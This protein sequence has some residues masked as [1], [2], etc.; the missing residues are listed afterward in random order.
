MH[1]YNHQNGT[2]RPLFQIEEVNFEK[3]IDN[4]HHSHAYYDMPTKPASLKEKIS[5][6]GLL[7]IP[8]VIKA[9]LENHF[10]SLII[11]HGNIDA[12]K[13]AQVHIFVPESLTRT[14]TYV[15]LF[16][17]SKN[18]IF[19]LMKKNFLDLAKAVVEQDSDILGKIYPNT[20]QKIKLNNEVGMDWVRRNFKSFPEV[21]EP[22]FSKSYEEIA[23][24]S[25]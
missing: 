10:P 1:D 17:L 2:H 24:V 8:K 4:G 15:L 13:F 3:F 9:H 7:F 21:V 20:P 22:N 25:T 12:E 16:G 23:T 5:N 19:N 6:P 14:R 11:F 18:P